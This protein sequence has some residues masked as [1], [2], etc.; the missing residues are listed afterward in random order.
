MTLNQNKLS[1]SPGERRF[2]TDTETLKARHASGRKARDKQS[3]KTHSFLF[4]P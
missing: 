4:V 2:R 1:F 3:D